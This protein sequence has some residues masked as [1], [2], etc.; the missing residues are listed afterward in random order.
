M[1]RIIERLANFLLIICQ[2]VNHAVASL[3][4]MWYFWTHT[5]SKLRKIIWVLCLYS[6][7]VFVCIPRHLYG[8]VA[9]VSSF[10]HNICSCYFHLF[11]FDQS[12]IRALKRAPAKEKPLH[13][14]FPFPGFHFWYNLLFAGEIFLGSF[15]PEA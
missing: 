3:R 11:S 14:F 9:F 7:S 12:V 2:F 8:R 4:C 6:V 5:L 13:S 1:K 15:W 10:L